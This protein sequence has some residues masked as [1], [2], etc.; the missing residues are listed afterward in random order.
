MPSFPS[1]EP[2]ISHSYLDFF[3]DFE[4]EF[5]AITYNDDL[6]SKL[7]EPSVSFQHIKEFDLNDETSLSEYDKEE[8]N[9]LY[10][11]D[12]FPLNI[13]FPN[14]LKSDKDIDDDEID[15]TQSSGTY[16]L[17]PY[18]VSTPGTECLKTIYLCIDSVLLANM[19]PLPPRDQRQPWLRYQVE[20]YT[21]DIVHN[22]EQRLEMTFGSERVIPD[23]G[24]LRDYWIEISSDR[25]FLGPAPSYVFIQDPVRRLC[26][27]MISCSIY[28]RGQAPKKSGA[29]LSE[30]YFIGRLAAHFGL[31]NDQG[32]RGLS[33]VTRELSMID[34]HELAR[35]NICERISDT[36]A[37]VV[38]GLERQPSATVGARRAAEDAPVVDEGAQADLEEVHEMRRSIMGL[39][40]D[41]D[42][43]ITDH[44]R[45]TTWMVS[46]MN[47]LM[48]DSNR[49]YQTFDKTLVG[50]SQLPYQ[51]RA[52]RRTGD[53]STSAPQLPDP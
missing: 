41:V 50:S 53:A 22:Y 39:R 46:C 38:P 34:L 24:D 42:R 51:R 48:D 43:S 12:S 35:L 1:P 49:T 11:N 4:N 29:R 27:R 31:V 10:F 44:G 7:T 25:D 20:G 21:K 26:H 9:V 37:W 3:K 2:T 28:S 33:M 17:T 47:Q 5:P 36:W 18:V 23:K 52:R 19:A 15:V 40:G 13:V 30:G 6:T 8:R 14:N 45:F 32:L 16:S